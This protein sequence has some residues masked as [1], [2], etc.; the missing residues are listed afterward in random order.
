MATQKEIIAEQNVK[1]AEL[2]ETLHLKTK[3]IGDQIDDIKA[4]KLELAKSI[5]TT[6]PSELTGF[7]LLRAPFADNQIGKLP[8]PTKDQTNALKANKSLG[9]RCEL[10]NGWHH[11]DVIHLDYVGHAAATDR[12]LDVDPAWSW[13]PMATN[14]VGLPQYDQSGGLWIELTILGVSRLGYGNA[15]NSTYKDVGAREKEVIGDALRNAAMRFGVALD[16]WHK[17]DLH[18]D[19][20]ASEKP[21]EVEFKLDANAQS[22]ID[23]VLQDCDVL[24]QIEDE[25][26]RKFIE[27]KAGL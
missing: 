26:Y 11:K 2:T 7:D 10:C 18:A 8:K 21:I 20:E 6:K 15:A 16:L 13:K 17:G 19:S 22:W 23:A 25:N 14:E 5:A 24:D 9:I 12:F 3:T 1:I 27:E 4:L